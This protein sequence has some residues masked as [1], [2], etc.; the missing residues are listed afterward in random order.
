M[1][2]VLNINCITSALLNARPF[3]FL[4]QDIE[5]WIYLQLLNFQSSYPD[6]PRGSI[7]YVL[8]TKLRIPDS[9]GRLDGRG[10][11]FALLA[12]ILKLIRQEFCTPQKE[13]RRK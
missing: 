3:K 6:M 8:M 4:P 1:Q 13:A 10:S 7:E 12:A 5:Y 2:S 9:S 11:N